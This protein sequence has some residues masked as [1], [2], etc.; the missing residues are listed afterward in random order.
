MKAANKTAIQEAASAPNA[1]L[2]TIIQKAKTPIQEALT[3]TTS[4]TPPASKP[5]RGRHTDSIG[6]KRGSRV[7]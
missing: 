2:D 4:P 3:S 5:L 7:L 1:D 6:I